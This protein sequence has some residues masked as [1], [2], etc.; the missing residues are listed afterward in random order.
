[1]SIFTLTI[2]V[3]LIL[4]VRDIIF[5]R[6]RHIMGHCKGFFQ[7]GQDFLDLLIVMSAA[8]GNMGIKKM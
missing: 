5:L 3:L 1:M 8:M 6:A 7:W 4:K 2:N